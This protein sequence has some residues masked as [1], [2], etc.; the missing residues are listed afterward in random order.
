MERPYARLAV[1]SRCSVKTAKRTIMETTS[2]DS[3]RF[4]EAKDIGEI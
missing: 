3:T 4:S 1:T 2:H